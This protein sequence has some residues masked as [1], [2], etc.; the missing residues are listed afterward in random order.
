MVDEYFFG[1]RGIKMVKTE[2]ST[3]KKRRLEKKKL[4]RQKKL[5]NEDEDAKNSTKST[6]RIIAKH[7]LKDS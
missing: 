1:T 6:I 3:Q 5:A 7:I 2:I 4:K